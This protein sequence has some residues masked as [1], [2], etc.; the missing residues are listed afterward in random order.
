M[1]FLFP[2]GQFGTRIQ[3]GPVLNSFQWARLDLTCAVICVRQRCSK[4]SLHLHSTGEARPSLARSLPY[5]AIK[6]WFDFLRGLAGIQTPFNATGFISPTCWRITRLLFHPSDD[7]LL[8]FQ[9]GPKPIWKI[10][11]NYRYVDLTSIRDQYHLSSSASPVK[12]TAYR[13]T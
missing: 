1:S 6:L 9:A 3:G 13:W 11:E 12:R 10:N 4:C 2:A 5:I 7:A 8:E